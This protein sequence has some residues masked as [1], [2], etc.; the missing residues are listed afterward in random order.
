MKHEEGFLKGVRD[1][2]IYF[3]SWLPETEPKAVLLI[4]H[5][6]A[7][8]SG[9]YMNIVNYFVPLGYAVYGMDH[10][11]HGKSDGKRVYVKRFEDYTDTLKI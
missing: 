8:H 2:N 6:L 10:P 5:G 11:G 9:R 1:P 7:E 4:V 3:Q